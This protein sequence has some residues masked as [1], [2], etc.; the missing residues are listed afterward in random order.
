MRT[1]SAAVAAPTDMG[2]P[3]GVATPTGMESA[4]AVEGASSNPITAEG[5]GAAIAMIGGV[6]AATSARIRMA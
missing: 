1:A 6:A 2:A 5:V 3:T 4:A